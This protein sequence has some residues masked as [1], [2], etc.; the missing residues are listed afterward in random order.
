MNSQISIVDLEVFYHVGVP[1]AERVKPQRLLLTVE[2]DFD[3]STAAGSD[4]LR[5]TVDYFAIGQRLLKF[6]DGREWK[7]IEK[8]AAD[9]ADLILAEFK[10][11]R[12]TV[13]VKKFPIP[14]AR[15]VSVKLSKP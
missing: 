7:L 6:G 5:D 11:S 12:V 15:H 4:D 13:E 1:E 8:L 3:F 10:P 14:Q 9:I 2:L